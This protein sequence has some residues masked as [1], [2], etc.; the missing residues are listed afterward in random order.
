MVK[1]VFAATAHRAWPRGATPRSR[2]GAE[3]GRTPC[4]RGGGQEELPHVRGQG[5]PR[6]V[7]G[8]DGAGM[9][10]RCYPTS[11]VRAAAERSYPLPEA[12]GSGWEELPHVQGAEAA[13]VQE[14]R[15]ELLHVQGQEGW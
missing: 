13:Q 8:C 14:G 4:L 3:T 6:K 11:E 2:S 7:P 10:E 12:R 15:E 1:T 9:A 5:Q